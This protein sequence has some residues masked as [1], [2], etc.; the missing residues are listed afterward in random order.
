MKSYLS[1]AWK[2]LKAQRV[3]AILILIAVI[4][5]S[6]M[7]TVI[8]QSIGILQAMRVQQA[9]RLNGSRYAT[10]HQLTQQQ[11]QALHDDPR[12]TDVG[13]VLYLGSTGLG[14]SSLKLSLR[15]YHDD[16]LA[17]YPSIGKIKEGRLPEAAKEVA[18]PEDAL[19]YLD[20]NA[21][22]GG[23]I[24]LTLTV[25]TMDGLLPEVEYTADF[26]LTGILESSYLGYSS[27]TVQGIVGK[28]SAEVLLPAAY[29]LISTDFKTQSKQDFQRI[30]R[31]LAETLQV[32]A[33][34][35]QYN[36]VLLNALGIAYDADEDS[37][38]GS[39]FPFMA[40]ACVLVGVLV[41][42]AAGLVIYNILKISISKRVREYGTLRAI[43][44]QRGQVYRLVSVQLLLLCG[45]GIPVGLLLG[46]LS[47]KGVLIAATGALNPDIFMANS[48]QELNSAISGAAEVKP[49]MLLA[50]IAVT[51]TFAMLAAFPAA[52]YA[53]RI[54]PTVAMSGQ[55]AKI[56][57]R[58]RKSRTIHHFEA[59][60]ARLNLKRGRGR[61]AI[62]ILSLVM[63][64]TV[65]V[66]L[67][68]FTGLL[69]ASSAVQDMY[70][71]DYALT[72][73]DAGISAEGVEK[74]R[75]NDA[76]AQLSTTRLSVFMP[77]QTLPFDTNLSLQGHETLQL[78]SV[79]EAQLSRFAPTLSAQDKQALLDETGCLVK[80]PI[81][82][83][84]GG[85]T[86][87]QTSLAVG[88]VVKLGDKEL[89]VVAL[90][91]SPVTI[92]SSGFTNGVQILVS[93]AMYC[94]LTGSDYYA[95][96]CPTLK[97]DADTSAFETWLD[98][99]CGKNPGTQWLSYRQ[100][101]QEMAE[102]FAQIK[103]LCWVLIALIGVIGVLNIINTVYSSIHT[104]IGEIGMQRAIGMS[105][106]SLYKTFLWE[107]AYY[108]I[109]ASVIG[110]VL[111]YV[112]CIFVGA[113]QTDTLQLVAV[114]VAAI[115]EA[116]AVSVAA[117][118]AATAIP[119]RAISRMNIV[120]SIETGE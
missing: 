64:I 78:A 93:D 30:V 88:D 39:G 41:L 57:R 89:R 80:N 19:Q 21:A 10:F 46:V 105:A 51:L 38:T 3:T 31:E 40:A 44:A 96:V 28:G 36:P 1:L 77:D 12:L 67:Q 69:D 54:S 74:L 16:A 25:S 48:A 15:E 47:A 107:G 55:T 109:F 53:A 5:S 111:G 108:G 100:S 35:I 32:D 85:E 60:Y 97:K 83:S 75:A 112:C 17:M 81:A 27:G 82:L 120:D 90:L 84:Y 94:E 118:L 114:P 98:G 86:V 23:T 45:I 37:D 11:A 6:L 70:T 20:E 62:T 49:I 102:S 2:E 13:D 33:A 14:S 99:W 103:M 73:E 61:T 91:D 18:L 9:E 24:R 113:A 29:R 92:G 34:F 119:L 56:K 43:G 8:G 65:F 79:D 104:R 50:S 110:A 26:T 101:S 59:W 106:A 115:L 116:A 63:S 58:I 72:N 4:L 87:Q 71:G 22:V 68:S 95:E 52:R 76:V 42:L 66:A 117:C 7:T